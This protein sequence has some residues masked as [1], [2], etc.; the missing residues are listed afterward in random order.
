MDGRVMFQQHFRLKSVKLEKYLSIYKGET[1]DQLRKGSLCLAD[2]GESQMFQLSVGEKKTYQ[3][4]LQINS[5]Y[6]QLI[7]VQLQIQDYGQDG[8]Y[9]RVSSTEKRL[10]FQRELVYIQHEQMI[11]VMHLF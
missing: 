6:T 8:K 9:L 2:K 7:N 5:I 3:P 10:L 11:N 1:A 4:A